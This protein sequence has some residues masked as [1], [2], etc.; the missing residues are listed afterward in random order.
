MGAIY[1]GGGFFAEYSIG[2]PAQGLHTSIHLV[3]EDGTGPDL[4]QIDGTGPH[5]D[6][7]TGAGGS[8]GSVD[9][10]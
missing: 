7:P 3:N 1:P 10:I 2:I 8:L 9:G 5:L 6:T 4:A